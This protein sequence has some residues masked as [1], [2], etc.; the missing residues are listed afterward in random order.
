MYEGGTIG[1]GIRRV[2]EKENEIS[3]LPDYLKQFDLKDT[4]VT[5]DAMGCNQTVIK[6]IRKGGGSLFPAYR[7]VF[8]VAAV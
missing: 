7:T 3:G 4:I 5:M 2:G 1:V 6:A 8:T